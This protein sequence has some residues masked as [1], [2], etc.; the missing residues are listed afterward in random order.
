MLQPEIHWGLSSQMTLRLCHSWHRAN[1]PIKSKYLET[2]SLHFLDDKILLI[3]I[4]PKSILPVN[5][6]TF[7]NYN[8]L[9][10]EDICNKYNW[11]KFSIKN[12]IK[13]IRNEHIVQMSHAQNKFWIR[14]PAPHCLFF[15]TFSILSSGN[16]TYPLVHIQIWKSTKTSPL[17]IP[18]TFTWVNL[19]SIYFQIHKLLLVSSLST[20]A[21]GSPCLIYSATH[22]MS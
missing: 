16:L 12:F 6:T 11:Q 1:T 19:S 22:Y 20:L 21:Q 3:V 8:W 9:C 13:H 5:M 14:F 7:I 2:L 4:N 15:F 17:T 18:S 10:T